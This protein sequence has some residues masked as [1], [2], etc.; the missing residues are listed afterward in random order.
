MIALRCIGEK[1]E[2]KAKD[3]DDQ[4]IVPYL[5]LAKS[6]NQL[7]QSMLILTALQPNFD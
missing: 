3:D 6:L 5:L 4:V 7:S 2:Q 1:C